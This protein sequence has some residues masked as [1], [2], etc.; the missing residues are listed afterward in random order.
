MCETKPLDNTP[1]DSRSSG[2]QYLSDGEK[3]RSTLD[4]IK[5]EL[6][7]LSIKVLELFQLE[8]LTK[9]EIAKVN[10]HS[11]RQVLAF[12]LQDFEGSKQMALRICL[13]YETA[14]QLSLSIFDI[15]A[16]VTS[17]ILRLVNGA[18]IEASTF[19]EQLTSTLI[20]QADPVLAGFLASVAPYHDSLLDDSKGVILDVA[21]VLGDA[22]ESGKLS[23]LSLEDL[24]F[25][26]RE[27]CALVRKYSNFLS[28]H[29][30]RLL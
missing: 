14:L 25:R 28:E 26:I 20:P 19:E 13:Y 18:E 21:E 17:N 3:A 5:L 1:C 29:F 23:S 2:S 6:L 16:R 15:S 30:T 11:P 4:P 10:S 12:Q 9:E 24:E 22:R 27:Q 7:A 8:V